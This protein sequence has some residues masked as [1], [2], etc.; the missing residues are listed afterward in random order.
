[1]SQLTKERIIEKALETIDQEGLHALSM[2]RLG[3][4]LGVDP[5]AVYYYFANKE[6]LITGVLNRAFAEL[7][8]PDVLPGTW[9]DQLRQ[10]VRAYN[11]LI[12]AH[13]NLVPYL[14]RV[15]GSVPVV[16]DIVEKVTSTLG[17]TGLESRSIVQIIDLLVSFAPGVALW[18]DEAGSLEQVHR[19]ISN[20]PE[21]R[22]PTVTR[23]M[24]TLSAEDLEDDFDFQMNIIISGIEQLVE[25]QR[26]RAQP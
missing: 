12:S 8:L 22:F 10:I 11:A 16:F 21:A 24:K 9:Q 6:G 5:K 19:Q 18:A 2:R 23:L 14:A 25:Q 4:N 13:P 7:N 20:L 15:D 26:G 17:D 3:H 1:M